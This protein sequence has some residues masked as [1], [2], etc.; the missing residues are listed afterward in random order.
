MGEPASIV[1]PAKLASRLSDNI[2]MS[3]HQTG[4]ARVLKDGKS[5][6]DFRPGQELEDTLSIFLVP[7][8]RAS[9]PKDDLLEH[10]LSMRLS[11]CYLNSGGKLSCITC[12]DPHVQPSAQQAPEYFRQK[13]LTCHTEKSCAI[14]LASRQ[15]KTPPDDCASCH[16]PKRDVTVISHSV[17]TN[18]R[19]VAQAEEPFPQVAFRLTTAQLPDLVDLSSDPNNPTAPDPLTRLQAYSQIVL[20]YP[21]YRAR[22]WALANQLKA[23]HE[24][25]ISVLEALADEAV[26][27]R[28]EEDSTPAIRYL[29]EAIEQGATNPVDFEELANL[30]MASGRDSEALAVL[31]QAINMAPYDANLYRQYAK[32]LLK[33]NRVREACAY[34]TDAAKKFPQDDSLRDFLSRCAGN[35]P[36]KASN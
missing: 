34:T 2:C 23:T 19:I 7:F 22:Y 8:D 10:Y 17:L 14:P 26:Q 25:N 12:H 28:S 11:R 6:R 13:C 36:G 21:E 15:R 1:N 24:K 27:K 5:Y 30:L 35:A 20:R 33:Q 32:L 3:C 16:M 31:P 4:E 9:A 29:K 18:H